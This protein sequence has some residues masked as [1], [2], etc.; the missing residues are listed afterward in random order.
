MYSLSLSLS[1][2]LSRSL[3]LALSLPISPLSLFNMFIEFVLILKKYFPMTF[4]LTDCKISIL[5]IMVKNE[6]LF[7]VNWL[8]ECQ[9]FKSF[10]I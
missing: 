4:S 7:K 2:S 9:L 8:I 1:R 10:I 5:H 6:F 3:F